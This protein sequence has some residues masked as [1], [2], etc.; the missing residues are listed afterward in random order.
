VGEHLN[1]NVN[2]VNSLD[3]LTSVLLSLISVSRLLNVF[4]F[5]FF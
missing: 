3:Y 2:I 1:I 4:D 5:I